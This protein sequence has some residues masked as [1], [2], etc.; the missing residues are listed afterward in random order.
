MKKD[1]KQTKLNDFNFGK[2]MAELE[3]ITT[4]LETSETDIDDAV[5]KFKRGAELASQ[6]KKYLQETENTIQ[7]IKADL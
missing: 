1:T 7:T 6:L 4:H 3:D 2:A 5:K